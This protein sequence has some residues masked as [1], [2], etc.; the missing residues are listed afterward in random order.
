M[1]KWM[2]PSYWFSAVA[3]FIVM[4][5]TFVPH[6]HTRYSQPGFSSGHVCELS[7][8]G[9][10]EF[11]LTQ[12]IGVGHLEF[13]NICDKEEISAPAAAEIFF[14]A[15]PV[16]LSGFFSGTENAFLPWPP[17]DNQFFVHPGFRNAIEL[18]GPPVKMC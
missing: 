11:S 13:F 2:K 12:D 15:N 17:P 5:H 6:S 10:L 3:M 7:L 4:A 8:L 18:R 14:P 1:G 16:R 9:I